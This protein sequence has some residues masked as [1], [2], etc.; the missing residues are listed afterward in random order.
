MENGAV[1]Q[2]TVRERGRNL[3]RS[4]RTNLTKISTWTWLNSTDKSVCSTSLQTTM[5][6]RRS[7]KPEEG[8]KTLPQTVRARKMTS[9][10]YGNTDTA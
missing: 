7:S 2:A 9:R 4:R 5:R 6:M 1:L 10:R 3:R 8:E